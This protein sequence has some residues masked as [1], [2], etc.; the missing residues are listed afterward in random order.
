[1]NNLSDEIDLL[2]EQNE[3]S[4]VDLL[5]FWEIYVQTGQSL[6]LTEKSKEI[7]QNAFLL[8]SNQIDIKS[9]LNLINHGWKVSVTPTVIKFAV[10][11]AILAS[12]LVAAGVT[13]IS[14]QVLP[15]ILPFLFD[16]EKIELSKGDK[17]LLA[18][19][20]LVEEISDRTLS[21]ELI[22][23]R[24]PQDLK[25]QLSQIDFFDFLERLEITGNITKFSSTS[26]MISD[27]Y[28]L[29]ISFT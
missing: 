4:Q 1:M 15:A 27:R 10:T 14:A 6:I 18:K 12:G 29:K 23:E 5:I 8:Y 26:F 19:I 21:P 16:F 25:S 28:Q 22:Y 24:L 2:P 3:I 17:F 20:K 7:C 11:G 9:S 13:G